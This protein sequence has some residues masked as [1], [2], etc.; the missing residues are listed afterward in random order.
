MNVPD[1]VIYHKTCM[2]GFCAA[3]LVWCEYGDYPEYVPAGYDDPIDLAHFTNKDVWV[4]DFSYKP[5]QL[6][7]LA[8]VA[9]SIVILDHHKSAAANLA[10]VQGFECGD[11]Q[12]F[13]LAMSGGDHVVAAFDMNRSGSLMTWHFLHG[14]DTTAPLL[15]RLVNDRDLWRFELTGTRETHAW[16][17][18]FEFDFETWSTCAS[19]LELPDE[20]STIFA[21]GAAIDR[22]LMKDMR[23]IANANTRFM[24]I[25]G[26]GVPV[27]NMPGHMSSDAG[28]YLAD[29][30]KDFAFAA[31]Y[32]IDSDDCAKFSLRSI[33][34]FDVSVVAS[35]FGGGGHRNAADFTIDV[36]DVGGFIQDVARDHYTNAAERAAYGID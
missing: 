26:E 29:K 23:D 4:L 17:T 28:N 13:E 7:A 32:Y 30:W 2:D 20:R 8:A 15:V 21:E 1:T 9:N 11:R 36:T 18:S 35:A 3:W 25:L 27:C 34:E 14:R 6:S 24:S 12:S 22:K 16:L 33:G 5:D 31:T 19:R 10:N